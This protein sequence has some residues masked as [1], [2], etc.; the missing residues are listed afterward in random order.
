ML[1]HI[2]DIMFLT[3]MFADDINDQSIIFLVFA[4]AWVA[5]GSVCKYSHTDFVM[6]A[7]AANVTSDFELGV[8]FITGD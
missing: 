1:A 4:N 8:F 5:F 6:A 2:K 3:A 7:G